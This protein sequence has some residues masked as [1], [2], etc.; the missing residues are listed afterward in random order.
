M[1]SL[2]CLGAMTT[3]PHHVVNLFRI[4]SSSLLLFLSGLVK[5]DIEITTI[6]VFSV[7]CAKGNATKLNDVG[8]VSRSSR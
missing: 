7:W 8:P 5:Q 4:F 6:S 3:L 1:E 2:K